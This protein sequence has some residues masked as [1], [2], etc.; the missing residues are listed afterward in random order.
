MTD[1]SH[2]QA[3]QPGE[4]RPGEG[5]NTVEAAAA[6]SRY[7]SPELGR[8]MVSIPPGGCYVSADPDEVLTTVLGSCVSACIRDVDAGVGGLNH[9]LLPDTGGT[10]SSDR[11]Y[12]Y[13]SYAME[14]L[15]NMILSRGGAKNRLEIKLFGGAEVLSDVRPIG[16]RNVAFA[17]NFLA[18]E[19]MAVATRHLGGKRARRIQYFPTTGRVRLRVLPGDQQKTVV[20]EEKAFT[21]Y[22]RRTDVEGDI[23]L[24]NE[25]PSK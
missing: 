15:I 14:A 7:F 3:T 2:S 13:G 12:R 19:R 10:D 8:T 1:A 20:A 21:R 6:V 22:L 25:K 4:A 5:D 24:F 11:G 23:E 17:E 9:F 18:T 16:R